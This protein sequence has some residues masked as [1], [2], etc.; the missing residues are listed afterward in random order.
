MKSMT[1]IAIAGIAAAATAGETAGLIIEFSAD[2]TEINVGD[3]VNWVVNVFAPTFEDESAYLGGFVG[4]IV[5]NVDGLGTAGDWVSSFSNN[6]TNATMDGANAM[7]INSFN[8]SLLGTND[9]DLV[10]AFSW[11]VTATAEGELSYGFS[12]V[13]SYFAGAGIFTVPE[14]FTEFDVA[15]S[16]DRVAIVP[17][18][19]ALGLLGLSGLTFIRRRR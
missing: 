16:S 14:E 4:D 7:E 8:A 13:W 17:T 1:I 11:S 9:S 10:T 2:A 19:G 15:L 6:A 18:P 3:T 12:G 5:A